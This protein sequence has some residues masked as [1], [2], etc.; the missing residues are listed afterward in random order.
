MPSRS[1]PYSSPYVLNDPTDFKVPVATPSKK[2]EW[3]KKHVVTGR[4]SKL[5]NVG[6][7]DP[8]LGFLAHA[9]KVVASDTVAAIKDPIGETKHD[10]KT[11]YTGAKIVNKAANRYAQGRLEAAKPKWRQKPKKSYNLAT[12]EPQMLDVSPGI[13]SGIIKAGSASIMR[14]GLLDL[15]ALVGKIPKEGKVR[16]APRGPSMSDQPVHRRIPWLVNKTTGEVLVGA[17]G[18]PHAWIYPRGANMSDF[19]QGWMYNPV[20]D[21]ASI[22][23]A[24]GGDFSPLTLREQRSLNELLSYLLRKGSDITDDQVFYRGKH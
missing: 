21:E 9:A 1:K 6:G 8:V 15:D 2:G 18:H 24:T 7:D 17:P 12:A 19:R 14:P 20:E 13:L 5:R 11:W 4:H 16:F 10:L 23:L 3:D 22:T